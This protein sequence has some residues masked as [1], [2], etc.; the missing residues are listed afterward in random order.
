MS[1]QI[2]EGRKT[3]YYVGMALMVIGGLLFLSTFLTFA[4]SMASSVR[5][6]GGSFGPPRDMATAPFQAFGGMG[7]LIAGTFLRKLGTRGLA[8]S[9]VILDPERARGELEPYSRMAGGMIKDGLEEADIHLD[10]TG[11]ERVIMIKCRSCGH[12]NEEDSK[13][14]QECGEQF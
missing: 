14:C 13:F 2:S 6:F 7:L 11:S 1:R 8:G 12:L 10:K 5:H 4:L 9:G 3:I